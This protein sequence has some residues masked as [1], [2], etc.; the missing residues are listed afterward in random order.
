MLFNTNNMSR[1][2]ALVCI[3]LA[4]GVALSSPRLMFAEDTSLVANSE[5]EYTYTDDGAQEIAM[6]G[7]SSD[8]AS[9]L[10]SRQA[11]I[12]VVELGGA[13]R[14]ETVAKEALHAFS[15]SKT[16]VVASGA[17]YA[18]SIAAAG[19][20]GALDCPIL[21][22]DVTNVPNVT[23]EALKSLGAKH[24]VLLGSESVANQAVFNQLKSIAGSVERIAG[25]DRYATQMAIY[26][27]GKN[28]GLWTGDTA[29]VASAEGFADA[30]SASPISY[31]LDAP[32]LFCDASRE[33]PKGQK[34]AI[35]SMSAIKNYLLIG[36]NVVTSDSSL[37][38]L[39]KIASGR[40]GSAKRLSGSDRYR[41]SQAIAAYA[42]SNLGFTWDGIAF[43]SGQGPYDALGG[44]AVQGKERSVLLL[45]DGTDRSA[46]TAVVGNGGRITSCLK[47]FGSAVVVPLDVRTS[48][49]SAFGIA[50]AQNVTYTS[51]GISRTA[52]ANLQVKRGEPYGYTF[53]DFYRV[54]DPSQYQYGTSEFYQFGVL[55]EG[56]S[57]VSADQIN[58][59][60]SANCTHSEQ[61]YGGTSSLRGSGSYFVEAARTYG[62]N[63]I[64]LMSHAIFESA[65]GCSSLARGWTP[66]QDGEVIVNGVHY[67]Y[68]KG[69]TYYNYFGIGAVDTN[70]LS[71]GRAM[72][73]KEGWTSPKA[74]ILGAAKWISQNY[75][76]R[77]VG[78]QNTLYLMKW[79]LAGA[80]A[81]GSA[82]HEYCTGLD[83]WTTGIAKIMDKCY[84]GAGFS[85]QDAPV[86]FDVPVFSG[87]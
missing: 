53:S 75:L 37:L 36:S 58:Q 67:P 7:G 60:I 64:Y 20:A 10:S 66:D 35:E 22:T 33:L 78:R 52:M 43:A 8:G 28:H 82:Y 56:H 70:A 27:Y 18:D 45:A 23:R 44:G 50:Y 81:T 79:D 17:G 62:V 14:Y 6:A 54:L 42:V 16:V 9:V 49:C 69:V 21:L 1:L 29:V 30:L 48:I 46:A 12:S 11:E 65:W 71:G 40:G 3:V 84:R 63:E 32:V 74:A 86:R 72:A 47:F 59:Y 19:L 80:V 2:R 38:Y 73:V 5:G 31:A 76:N 15:S 34:S 25:S 77:S 61:A 68:K 13:D 85:M 24:I 87:N 4:A 83:S 55:N 41:T 26:N 57:G 39:S 51:Y